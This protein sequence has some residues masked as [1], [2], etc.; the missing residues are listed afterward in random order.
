METTTI[1]VDNPLDKEKGYAQAVGILENGGVVAFPTET[2]YGLGALATDEAAVNE[3]FKA[4]GRPSDN[5]LIVHIGSK[6]EV[7]NFATHISEDARK[8]MD[9]FWPG[10]LTLVFERIPGSIATNVTPGVD[11][12]GIRM[13]NHPIALA[14]LRM[15]KGP[16]A[17]PSANRSGKPSPTEAI[18]V[19]ED[20][21][22]LIPLV[23]DGGKTGLGLESTVLDMTTMPPTILRPGGATKEMIEAVIGEVNDTENNGNEAPRSP[24]MRYKHYAPEAPLFV[25]EPNVE[26]T[27]AI[28]RSLQVDGKKVAVIGPD[29]LKISN[30]DWYFGLGLS[31]DKEGMAANLYTALRRCNLTNADIILAVET[32]LSGVGAAFMNRLEKAAEGNKID[33]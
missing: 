12:V 7:A 30:A 20:L 27:E 22:G 32:D 16:L 8:L 31:D 26:K 3:I 33:S 5:P 6:E 24:G 17:A 9:T 23:I 11:T 19:C 18:H 21:D 29:D 10:P 2:V 1:F 15:L 28:I 25:I 14:L 4:K 13:P